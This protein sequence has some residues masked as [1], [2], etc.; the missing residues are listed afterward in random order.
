MVLFFKTQ[1][2]KKEKN[3]T[4]QASNPQI[5][6]NKIYQIYNYQII[7]QK[8]SSVTFHKKL[9]FSASKNNSQRLAESIKKMEE[10]SIPFCEVNNDLKV[11][12]VEN[13]SLPM[14]LKHRNVKKPHLQI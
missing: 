6:F 8:K 5:F 10:F 7:H 14:T 1:P 11:P 3:P 2:Y 12:N 4:K 9:N 13:Q